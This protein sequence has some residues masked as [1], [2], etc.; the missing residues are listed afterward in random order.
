MVRKERHKIHLEEKKQLAVGTK[1]QRLW[2]HLTTTSGIQSK[3]ELFEAA[4]STRLESNQSKHAAE[5]VRR[6]ETK[7]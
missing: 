4:Y 7:R 1:N 3:L 2:I 5:L 6:V